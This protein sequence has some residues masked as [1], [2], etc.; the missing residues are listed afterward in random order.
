MT[1]VKIMYLPNLLQSPQNHKLLLQKLLKTPLFRTILPLFLVI[2]VLKKVITSMKKKHLVF[3]TLFSLAIS[4]GL[5]AC[6]GQ[7]FPGSQA[8]DSIGSL[9]DDKKSR[10]T[11]LTPLKAINNSINVKKAWQVNTGS[12]NHITK[13]HPFISEKSI[14]VAG[15]HTASAWDKHSGKA[16]W[17]TNIGEIISAGVNS[18]TSNQQIF[19]GTVNGNAIS[20]DANT[21]KV[22]WIERLSS[23]ILSVSRAK[24]NRVVFR[25]IDGKLHGLTSDSGEIIW[26]QGQRTP[27]LSQYG[28]SVPLI[29]GND[30][31]RSFVVAGFDNGK[32][33]AYSL[34][35]GQQAWEIIIAEPK[36]QN[37]LDRMVDVDGKISVMGT[38]LFASSLNGNN[39]GINL[40]TGKIGWSKAFSSTTGIDA[41]PQGIY[42]SD[43]KGNVWKFQAQTG[44]PIWKMDD[45]MRREPTTPIIL[46]SSLIIVGDQKGNIHWINSTTGKFVARLQGDPAGFNVAPKVQVN[47]VYTLGKNGILSKFILQ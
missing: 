10:P 43:T 44:D 25:T 3:S 33:A 12:A 39:V 16:L 26:R 15:N 13:I 29:L 37:E 40:A 6:S 9:F 22:R 1:L 47:S 18:D 24:D 11:P 45:L 38:A 46:N 34:Q 19:I 4:I 17:K 2:K 14:F 35:H 21:G 7:T 30:P 28:A 36:G 32:L 27:A 23:E 31:S 41:S 20:L 5:S 8:L 42:S